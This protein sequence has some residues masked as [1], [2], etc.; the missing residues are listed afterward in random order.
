MRDRERPRLLPMAPAP[1]PARPG[2]YDLHPPRLPNDYR[3]GPGLRDIRL[4]EVDL[5]VTMKCNIRCDF[6]SVRA[7]EYG[8]QDLP[9]DQIIRFIDQAVAL[10]LE[11]LHFLGGEPTIRD[12]L[13]TMVHHASSQGVSTRII[14][15]GMLLTR[16]RIARLRDLGLGEIMVS[17]DGLR[18]RHTRLRRSGSH[19]WDKT[20]R[21]VEDAI[22]LGLWTRVSATAYQTNYDDIVPLLRLVNDLGAQC[23]SVFLGSPLGRGHGMIAD[24]I[25][26]YQWRALQEAVRDE[27]PT[28][29]PDLQLVME[30][31]F[32]WADGP[33]VD[34]GSLKGRGTGCNTLLEDYDYLI[35]R[36]DGH[37][38]QC[39]FFMTEGQPIGTIVDQP[40]EATLQYGLERADYRPFTVAN[41][42]CGDCSH[43]GPC[44]TGCRGYAYLYKNDW[45]KTDPR[46]SK[47]EP[48]AEEAPPY[49]PLC[50][51]LKHNVRTGAFGGS[52]EQALRR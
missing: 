42:K 9:L 40:L 38:Y 24:V 10:G 3:P 25:S 14:T 22:A 21:T 23:F 2:L 43:A 18:D 50:P 5:Y 41:D 32:Q 45:L 11:E 26:P 28:L 51:I 17:V 4:H 37:L 48:R 7:G 27:S 36:S 39:V 34:R 13:E 47:D 30:Q 1:P 15:N 49:F 52:S 33:V 44:G 12:D 16:D 20:L 46:C 8:H 35:V 19:G 29:R 31:G 6:C